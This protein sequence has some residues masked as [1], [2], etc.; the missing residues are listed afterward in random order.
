MRK[1]VVEVTCMCTVLLRD[2][3][4][5]PARRCAGG[6]LKLTWRFGPGLSIWGRDFPQGG[7]GAPSCPALS[8]PGA[9]AAERSGSSLLVA[10]DRK[11]E[12]RGRRSSDWASP[13]CLGLL[14]CSVMCLRNMSRNCLHAAGHRVL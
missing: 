12:S 3:G 1:S 11:M 9:E 4:R 7:L 6:R 10:G 8:G 13:D 14:L 2:A 5:L